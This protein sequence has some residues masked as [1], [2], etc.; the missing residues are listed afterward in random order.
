MYKVLLCCYKGDIQHVVTTVA[1]G[2]DRFN[3]ITKRKCL[4]PEKTF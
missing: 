1:C 3:A 4:T 2:V